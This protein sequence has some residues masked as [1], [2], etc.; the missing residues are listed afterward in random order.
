MSV[1]SLVTQ[2]ELQKTIVGLGAISSNLDDHVN[3]SLSKS[4]GWTGIQQLYQD[5]GGCYHS[6]LL[7]PITLQRVVRIVVGDQV[8]YVPAQVSGGLNAAVPTTLDADPTLPPYT[9]ISSSAQADPALDVTVGSPANSTLVTSFAN[10]FNTI[11]GSA[12]DTLRLHAGSS[13]ETVHGGLS[14]EAFVQTDRAG[15][16]VGRQSV[17]LVIDGTRYRIIC[18]KEAGGPPQGP[19]FTN[20]CPSYV[21]HSTSGEFNAE[22]GC[23][24]FDHATPGNSNATYVFEIEVWGS[25]PMAYQWEYATN[26]AS[27]AW[28]PIQTLGH[29]DASGG[30]FFD[31]LASGAL[32]QTIPPL[33]G[34]LYVPGTQSTVLRVAATNGSSTEGEINFAYAL[35]LTVN[36]IAAGG[37]IVH[38]D[39]LIFH[40]RD[41]TGG[42]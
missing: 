10:L 36:N 19:H 18:D 1:A 32:G 39:M 9:G 14:A 20:A 21:A 41:E 38:S 17:N 8:Y 3:A 16:T 7:G 23:T 42:C 25:P 13:P 26:A 11:A 22:G 4:H 40:M 31:V 35:R 37:S 24:W 5:S 2:S 30:F 33:S 6:G 15:H 27:P 34:T 12:N 29:Y 28:T